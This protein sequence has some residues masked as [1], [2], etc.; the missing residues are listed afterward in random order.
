MSI[1]MFYLLCNGVGRENHKLLRSVGNLSLYHY[2]I[3]PL[4]SYHKEYAF[5]F[6]V[7]ITMY[8]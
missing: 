7:Q 1:T 2:A 3:N 8:A 4:V 5:L 6:S